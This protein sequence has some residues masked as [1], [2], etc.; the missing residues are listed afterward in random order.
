MN[1]LPSTLEGEGQGEGGNDLVIT[2][3][4]ILPPAYRQAGIKGEES[5]LKNWMSHS[6]LRGASFSKGKF[7]WLR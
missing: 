3:T 7:K 6:R 2:P 5:F 4:L 1:R